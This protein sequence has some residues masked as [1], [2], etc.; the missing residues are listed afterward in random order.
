[1][2]VILL[3]TGYTY[4]DSLH[5]QTIFNLRGINRG[6]EGYKRYSHYREYDREG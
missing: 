1:M 4:I 5:K 2:L 3:R 6:K